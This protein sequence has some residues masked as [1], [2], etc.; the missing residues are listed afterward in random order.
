MDPT[1]QAANLP[2]LRWPF[3]LLIGVYIFILSGL[4]NFE[5][6]WMHPESNLIEM[7][8]LKT[9]S[10]LTAQD[11]FN[12]WDWRIDEEN[13]PRTTRWVTWNMDLLN[14]KFRAWL[15][16]RLPPHPSLS[17]T[18]PL[19]LVIN[20]WLL[21]TYLRKRKFTTDIALTAAAFYL[22][23]PYLLSSVFFLSR[24]GR[25]MAQFFMW[26]ALVLVCLIEEHPKKKLYS[27]GFYL[28]L[29]LG[30]FCDE[31]GV[32]IFPVLL[33]L[34]PEFIF[35]RMRWLWMLTAAFLIGAAYLWGIKIMSHHVSGAPL[36]AL[37]QYDVV[38]QIFQFNYIKKF[39]NNLGL[40][41]LSPLSEI[42]GLVG[43]HPRAPWSAK[44][45]WGAG[46]AAWSMFALLTFR[47]GFR[48]MSFKKVFPWAAV[49]GLACLFHD[50]L[51]SS[52]ANQVWGAFGY[53]SYFSII[54]PLALAAFLNFLRLG[55]ILRTLLIACILCSMGNVFLY[56]NKFLKNANC[57][58][59]NGP[60][61]LIFDGRARYF[62]P[63]VQT[64]FK[65]KQLKNEIYAAWKSPE[66]SLRWRIPRELF[67]LPLELN[68]FKKDYN[69]PAPV[70]GDTRFYF[71]EKEHTARSLSSVEPALFP[72]I[73]NHVLDFHQGP[74]SLNRGHVDFHPSRPGARIGFL[75]GS[76]HQAFK[77]SVSVFLTEA[78]DAGVVKLFLNKIPLSAVPVDTYSPHPK[79]K[80]LV[81]K[82]AAF[83]A[84]P[85]VLFIKVIGRN[86]KSE[87]MS[88]RIR[89]VGIV[90][91]QKIGP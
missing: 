84:G 51:L 11:F 87:G 23:T 75:L 7:T 36:M 40:N 49:F 24:T 77:G 4:C 81:F 9:G 13:V 73:L 1:S 64:V 85:N 62:D 88:V 28:S 2:S 82:N 70:Y 69:P 43:L 60:E 67:W 12:M 90:P 55:T 61:R 53:G 86:S 44:L 26:A 89:A 59:Q 32:F 80:K 25:I 91:Q 34:H 39:F 50:F 27:I 29:I 83:R 58:G 17:L 48:S 76:D 30:A 16:R 72:L 74:I 35:R 46:T 3:L 54:F 6:T 47:K 78:P 22:M 79:L 15:W 52:V 8:Y 63:H 20:P 71:P 21:I 5:N 33:A 45:I 37:N 66:A 19:S 18:W 42:M 10:G 38:Q 57:Y 56:T 68:G 14:T 31:T 65:D 41:S